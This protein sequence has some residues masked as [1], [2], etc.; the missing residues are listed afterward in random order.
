MMAVTHMTISLAGATII[1][2]SANP[3]VMLLAAIGSQIPDLDTTKSWVGLAFYPLARYLEERFPHRSLTHSF[4]LTIVIA[5]LSLPVLFLYSWQLWAALPIGHLLSCFSDCC[6][7]LGCQFFYPVNKDNWVMGLNPQNR[8]E[9]GKPGE[10]GV[11]ASAMCIFVISFYLVT[12]GG[13]IKAWAQ[14]ALFPTSR[15]AIEVL[16][17]QNQ[18]AVAIEVEG[19]RRVDNSKVKERYWAIASQGSAI[20]AKSPSGKILRIGDSGE[21]IPKRVNVLPDRLQ[22]KIRRQR[23]EE[24][25]AEEWINSLPPDALVVGNLLIEDAVEINLPIPAPGTMQNIVKNGG[26]VS[27]DHVNPQQLRPIEE[28]FILSGQVVIKQL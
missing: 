24:A 10:Y 20:I 4:F 5:L 18:K 14:K 8:L 16:R 12:G 27:L 6:T 11:L 7:K 21:I 15:T 26:G 13:G 9:T 17:Q 22:L 19:L 3:K 23:I 2:G 1:T 28:F 25:E